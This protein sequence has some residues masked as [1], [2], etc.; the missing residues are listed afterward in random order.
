[1]NILL[2]DDDRNIVDVIVNTFKVSWP[3]TEIVI[4]YTGNEGLRKA[5]MQ[6]P[7]IILLDLGLPDI[8][9]FDVI[10]NLRC[11]CDTPIM[12]ISVRDEEENIVKALGLGADDYLNKPFG[13]L[14]LVARIKALARRY[15]REEENEALSCGNVTLDL[16]SSKLNVNG[17]TFK[18][19]NTEKAI[20]KLLCTD[21]G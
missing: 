5:R 14:E 21:H 1:M 8:S 13:Q 9:G 18:L 3:E 19:T 20:V 16:P 17:E 11:F 6:E 7:D 4:A 2:I 12:I 15:I 10:E